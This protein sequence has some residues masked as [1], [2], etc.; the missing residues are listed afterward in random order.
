[1]PPRLAQ[2]L[3]VSDKIKCVNFI[4]LKSW[5]VSYEVVIYKKWYVS[6]GG[7]YPFSNSNWNTIV[8][9]ILLIFVKAMERK[10]K[11][12]CNCILNKIQQKHINYNPHFFNWSWPCVLLLPILYFLHAL[13]A[14][15]QVLAPFLDEWPHTFIP[16]GSVPFV[17]LAGLGCCSVPL[18][19]ITGHG[20]TKRHPKES[21]ALQTT[22]FLPL[23]WKDNPISPW[24][25][26]S[27]T[28]PNTVF[29]FL[30]CWIKH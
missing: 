22:S 25:S 2:Y 20:S 18:T 6:L 13:Q 27:I 3:L 4:F 29:L 26:G 11:Y 9:D 5:E 17:M 30:A 23:L 16:D 28:S 7:G 8:T 19:L 14:P 12:L 24:L 1:V 21:P 15:Q 10:H